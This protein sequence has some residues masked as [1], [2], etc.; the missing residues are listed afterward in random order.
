ML[1]KIV[2]EKKNYNKAVYKYIFMEKAVD[3]E[4]P[5]IHVFKIL[6]LYRMQVLE[7]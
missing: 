5:Q 7:Y 2:F 4:K 1:K 6:G 3:T